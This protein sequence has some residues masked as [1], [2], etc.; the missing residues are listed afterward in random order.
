LTIRRFRAS[1]VPLDEFGSTEVVE[2]LRGLVRDRS[3]LLISGSTGAGKTT[4]LNALATVIPRHERVVTIEDTAELRLPLP[5]VVRLEARPAS[6]E[7]TGEV[8]LRHLVRTVLRMR[9]D[10]IVVGECRGGEALDLLQAMHTG[11]RGTLGTIHANGTADALR[12]L[13]TLVMLA[14]SGLPVT[15][16][17]EQIFTALDAVVHV[18]RG[19]SMGKRQVAEVAM[20]DPN[21][22]VNYRVVVASGRPVTDR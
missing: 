5:H 16:V 14:E 22:S 3:N 15:A 18:E 12:R 7:G 21:D 4:L 9:P 17:R 6:A 11:H 19:P 1:A 13:E 20:L 10:R 8:T 2:L